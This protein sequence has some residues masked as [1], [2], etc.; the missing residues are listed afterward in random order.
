MICFWKLEQKRWEFLTLSTHLS[1]KEFNYF[2]KSWCTVVLWDFLYKSAAHFN[3]SMSQFLP[4]L[5][6]EC[7]YRLIEDFDQPDCI[8]KIASLFVFLFFLLNSTRVQSNSRFS[9]IKSDTQNLNLAL[10]LALFRA[11]VQKTT[12]YKKT[13]CDLSISKQ[14]SF[15]C[16]V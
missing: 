4:Q 5:Y 15:S 13:I 6:S 2:F 11:I 8:Y 1:V 14:K 12:F 3:L 16:L 7:R 10:S 9:V